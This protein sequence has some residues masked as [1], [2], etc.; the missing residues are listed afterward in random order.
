MKRKSFAR[1]FVATTLSFLTLV[2]G[3]AVWMSPRT[4]GLIAE[5]GNSA[6]GVIITNVRLFDGHEARLKPVA[7]VRVDGEYISDIYEAVL[8]ADDRALVIEGQGRVLMP[9]LIDFHVHFGMADGQPVWGGGP[10]RIP[11]LARQ[12][13]S[14]LY[15]GVTSVVLGSGN[16][17]APFLP[18]SLY[19]PNRYETGRQVVAEEGHPILMLRELVPWPVNDYF[20]S[21]LTLPFAPGAVDEAAVRALAAE[22]INHVKLIFDDAIP[23]GAPRLTEEDVV[24]VSGIVHAAGKPLYVHPGDRYEALV[25]ATAGADV[26]MHTPFVDP[27]LPEDLVLLAGA[28]THFVT[29]SQIWLWLARGLPDAPGFSDLERT[30]MPVPVRDAFMGPREAALASYQSPHFSTSYLQRIPLFDQM[31]ERNIKAMYQAG[32]PLVAG[33]DTGVPGLTYGASLVFELERLQGFGMAPV[34]VLRAATSV[35]GRLLD[36]DPARQGGRLG[37]VSVG[38][39]AELILLPGNPL[40]DVRTLQ[41]LDL[42]FSGGRVFERVIP[43]AR[44]R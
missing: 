38:A 16:P 17:L 1:L 24:R 41:Q 33:T 8:P 5:I 26:L 19:E 15:A 43:L 27:F 23:W 4:A 32:V 2:V 30:L 37:T 18:S 11:D 29:T 22:D 9:S 7:G 40:E 28:G 20:A 36:R 31:V 13:E 44:G 34:D 25:A 14:F 42:V 3:A 10:S 12:N 35:P 39:P 21:R 6:N